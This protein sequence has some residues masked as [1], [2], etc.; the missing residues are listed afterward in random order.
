M[1]LL[2]SLNAV[3]H[4]LCESLLYIFSALIFHELEE[5]MYIKEE[6]Y[7]QIKISATKIRT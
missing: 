7:M 1:K 3:N 5:R 2:S 4:S 6:E